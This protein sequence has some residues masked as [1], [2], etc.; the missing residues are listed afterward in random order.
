MDSWF[1]L[2][3][4]SGKIIQCVAKSKTQRDFGDAFN[5]GNPGFW[6]SDFTEAPMPETFGR[7][8]KRSHLAHFLLLI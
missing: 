6:P 2:L 7:A 3:Q 8:S 1:Q 5:A 4:W